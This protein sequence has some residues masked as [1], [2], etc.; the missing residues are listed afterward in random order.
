MKKQEA[1]E[2]EEFIEYLS[3]LVQQINKLAIDLTMHTDE[4]FKHLFKLQEK[5]GGE[6]NKDKRDDS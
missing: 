4:F 2:I 5:A 3:H 6:P 1:R